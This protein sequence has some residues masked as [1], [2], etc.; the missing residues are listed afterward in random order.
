MGVLTDW[1][2]FSELLVALARYVSSHRCPHCP[3]LCQPVAYQNQTCQPLSL[4]LKASPLVDELALYDVVN[5]PGVAADL[6]HISSVA[7][8]KWL[9]S[10][11]DSECRS[12]LVY[13]K[14][15]DICPLMM[16]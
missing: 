16:A 10:L 11:K 14:F 2:L 1:Q 5:T 3:T 6:S 7:V 8:R 15:P 12:S 4:L 13:R 9:E